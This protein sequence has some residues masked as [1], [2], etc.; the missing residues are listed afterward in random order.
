V[1]RCSAVSQRRV[2]AAATLLPVL[3][4]REAG[5]STYVSYAALARPSEQE[6]G[7]TRW[8]REAVR[9]AARK[10]YCLQ[11]PGGGH[12]GCAPVMVSG[13]LRCISQRGVRKL[14]AKHV[15]S[16]CIYYT[17]PNPTDSSGWTQACTL[18]LC[19]KKN[20]NSP[21][22]PAPFPASCRSF[23]RISNA[24]EGQRNTVEDSKVGGKG[25]M[26]IRCRCRGGKSLREANLS[27]TPSQS[28]PGP[29]LTWPPHLHYLWHM[30][31]V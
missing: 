27:T 29:E 10:H 16:L 2:I 6:A 3:G 24:G 26:S 17:H 28:I 12:D 13:T 23:P 5:L 18:C 21:Y 9:E 15:P 7:R 22:Y 25:L 19:T 30:G 14:T 31:V 4:G 20:D 11:E 1:E 8:T